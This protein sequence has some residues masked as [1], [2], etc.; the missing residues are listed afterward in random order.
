MAPPVAKA[1]NSCIIRLF[2]WSTLET[3]MPALPAGSMR[4][5]MA[6]SK[7]PSEVENIDSITMGAISHRSCLPVNSEY[8]FFCFAVATVYTFFTS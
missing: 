7:K 1:E 8:L 5:T 6:E 2:I 4:E 3:A